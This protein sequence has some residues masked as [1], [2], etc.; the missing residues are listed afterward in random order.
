MYKNSF[1]D[2]LAQSMHDVSPFS[3]R[4]N[5]INCFNYIPAKPPV[6]CYEIGGKF[7]GI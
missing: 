1:V 4:E 7:T 5:K 6:I 3:F 2:P